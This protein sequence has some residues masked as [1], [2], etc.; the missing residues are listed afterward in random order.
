[1]RQF[2]KWSRQASRAASGRARHPRSTR[3]VLEKLEDR[4][5]PSAGRVACPW[6]TSSAHPATVSRRRSAAR[7]GTSSLARLALLVRL[8]FPYRNGFLRDQHPP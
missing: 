8:M 7:H 1:M 6:K 4:T 2:L 3:P 5:L